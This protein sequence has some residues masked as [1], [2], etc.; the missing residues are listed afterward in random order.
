MKGRLVISLVSFLPFG[1]LAG[2]IAKGEVS[3]VVNVLGA[4]KMFAVHL[5]QGANGVCG[6]TW[7]KIREANFN[8]NIESYKFAFSLATTALFTNKKIRTHNYTDDACDG[9]TFICLFND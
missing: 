7:I 8:G 2:E 4:E 3:E 5:K 6:N 1:A 9:A